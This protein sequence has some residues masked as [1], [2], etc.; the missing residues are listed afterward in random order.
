MDFPKA[1]F[2]GFWT[3]AT[4]LHVPK[5]RIKDA[6]RNLKRVTKN[7][8]IG[9]ISL[10]EGEGESIEKQTGRFFSYYTE[11]ELTQILKNEGIQ[12]IEAGKKRQDFTNTTW[13][14]FFVRNFAAYPHSR[15]SK[16]R[17]I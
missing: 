7:G 8:G 11:N 3:A 10:I 14:M 4:L 1:T 9:F 2:D 6:F 5:N 13:L 15:S 12:I 17:I 16:F